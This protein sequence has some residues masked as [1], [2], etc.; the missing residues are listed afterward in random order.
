[1]PGVAGAIGPDQ[2]QP[3]EPTNT[4]EDVVSL[5]LVLLL[6]AVGKPVIT[7][8]VVFIKPIILLPKAGSRGQRVLA[9]DNI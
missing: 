6:T 9:G 5:L 2:K 3:C 4:S 7:T 8:L 1:M